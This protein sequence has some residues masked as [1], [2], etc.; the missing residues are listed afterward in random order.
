MDT[1]C[2]TVCR[3]K[4][5][6]WDH[7][8]KKKTRVKNRFTNRLHIYFNSHLRTNDDKNSPEKLTNCVSLRP[9]MCASQ[10]FLAANFCANQ[11]TILVHLQLWLRN[12]CQFNVLLYLLPFGGNSNVKLWSPNSTPPISGIMMDTG[13]RK[14]Y[15]SKCRPHILLRLPYTLYKVIS[16]TVWPKYT[17]RQTD[18]QKTDDRWQT[19]RSE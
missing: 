10:L 8:S 7:I 15:Q 3:Q 4:P 19:E 16:Y 6:K 14:W 13:G 5:E 17:T 11:L 2:S 18:T 12:A 9:K 1:I